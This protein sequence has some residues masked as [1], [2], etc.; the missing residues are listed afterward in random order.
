M[1]NLDKLVAFIK[2]HNF[3]AEKRGNELWVES[4]YCK[5]GKAFSEWE[6]IE[7]TFSAVRLW[8]GY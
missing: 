1:N 5:D 4:L 7:P 2:E 8:L 3:N 6:K